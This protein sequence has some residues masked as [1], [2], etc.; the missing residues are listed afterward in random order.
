[1]PHFVQPRCIELEKT[2]CFADDDPCYR[3]WRRDSAEA[4]PSIIGDAVGAADAT[5]AGTNRKRQ[6]IDIL[7]QI[8]AF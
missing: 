6:K 3:P 8:F 5:L 4:K 2:A 7:L 1:V